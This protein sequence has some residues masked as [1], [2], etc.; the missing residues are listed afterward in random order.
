MVYNLSMAISSNTKK[1]IILLLMAGVALGLSTSPRA[2]KRVFRALK[3]EWKF[4][5]KQ[6]L[7]RNV[8]KLEE[9]KMIYYRNKGEWWNIE[10]TKK[11]KKQAQK[12]G[13]NKLEI[14]KPK[15]WDKKWRVVIFDIPE[16]KKIVREAL[17]K[18]IQK[19]GFQELQK[20]VF[21]YPYP[22]N[23]EIEMVINFF[24]AEKF[25]KQFIATD[26]NKSTEKKLRKKFKL[27]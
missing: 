18:K 25:A 19:L 10:L 12:I 7:Y 9:Q 24:K 1:K 8:K 5:D 26:F 11:G 4:V 27:S 16:N 21:I 6:K 15:K 13:F 22:C 17:R 14:S 20:S 2:Q 3:R 23:K